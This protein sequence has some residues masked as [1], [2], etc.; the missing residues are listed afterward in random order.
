MNIW[1]FS[2]GH[3]LARLKSPQGI[4]MLPKIPVQRSDSALAER[5]EQDTPIGAMPVPFQNEANSSPVERSPNA[6][7][8]S[9]ML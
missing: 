5:F 3:H 4:P 9:S 7:V 1:Q 8:I 2:N 6:S